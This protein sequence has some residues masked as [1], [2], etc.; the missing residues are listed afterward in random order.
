MYS[1]D[2]YGDAYAQ[3]QWSAAIQALETQCR[4][5]GEYCSEA[6][7]ARNSLRK[8]AAGLTRPAR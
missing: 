1:P 7:S 4:T 8:N 3:Q 5:T 6:Q 2:I